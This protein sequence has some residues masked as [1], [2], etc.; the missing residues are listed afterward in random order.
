MVFSNL[1]SFIFLIMSKKIFNVF[2]TVP[3]SGFDLA[4]A[5]QEKFSQNSVIISFK[6]SSRVHDFRCGYLVLCDF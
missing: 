4:G 2:Q 6:Q 5:F 3:I 1:I